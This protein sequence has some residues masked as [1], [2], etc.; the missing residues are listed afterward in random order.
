MGEGAGDWDW[1]LNWLPEGLGHVITLD[2][3]KLGIH[4]VGMFG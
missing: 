4:G 2:L 1:L 3:G